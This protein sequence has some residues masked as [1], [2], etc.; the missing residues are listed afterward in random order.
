MAH[1]SL[2]T[3][4]EGTKGSLRPQ[5]DCGRCPSPCS[6]LPLTCNQMSY[7]SH[8]QASRSEWGTKKRETSSPHTASSMPRD[9]CAAWCCVTCFEHSGRRSPEIWKEYSCIF[10]TIPVSTHS[11]IAFTF[12][13]LIHVSQTVKESGSCM[14]AC[15]IILWFLC[16]SQ[17]VAWI[18][19]MFQ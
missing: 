17:F 6:L 8:Y 2:I 18:P 9:D 5:R 12:F 1:F 13:S 4:K 11:F 7:E 14:N 15:L 16:I 19:I 10:E 3:A